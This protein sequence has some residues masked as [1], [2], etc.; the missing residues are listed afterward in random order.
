MQKNMQKMSKYAGN[1]QEICRKYAIKYAEKYATT[2]TNMQRNMT[3]MQCGSIMENMQENMQNLQHLQTMPKICKICTP[4]LADDCNLNLTPKEPA[5]GR[6]VAAAAGRT[7]RGLGGG[8]VEGSHSSS[9]SGWRW[10]W[11]LQHG[12]CSGSSL[13]MACLQRSRRDL[14][15]SQFLGSQWTQ[16][17]I[18]FKLSLC[19]GQIRE[20]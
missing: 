1:M 18:L 3:N 7:R 17:K 16:F 11:T 10:R 12:R 5:R 19:E 14:S 9:G 15:H 20:S 6:A 4:H 13:S 8:G 2:M